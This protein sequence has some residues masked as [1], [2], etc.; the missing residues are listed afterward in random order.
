MAELAVGNFLKFT[1]GGE[2]QYRFQNFFIG[3][4][5]TITNELDANKSDPYDFV[6]YGFS[7]VTINRTGDGTDASLL[8]PNSS[9]NIGKLTRSLIKDAVEERW[10]AYV[11]VL[12]VDPD[13]QASFTQLS[14]YYGQVTT[15]SWDSQTVTLSINSVLDAVGGD[16]PHRKI[17]Q[18]LVGNLPTTSGVR[19]Q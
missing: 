11:R 13:D 18:P 17:T 14:Q 2:T 19:L 9:G 8:F 7:G 10:I 6:P 4:T 1:S 16:V 3:E 12:I 15:A 5:I